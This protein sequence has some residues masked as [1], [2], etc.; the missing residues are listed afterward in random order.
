MGQFENELKECYQSMI[1]QRVMDGKLV[2]VARYHKNWKT[3]NKQFYLENIGNNIT[4]LTSEEAV[5]L[6]RQQKWI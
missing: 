1:A 5:K 2:S 4:I 6:M 3:V